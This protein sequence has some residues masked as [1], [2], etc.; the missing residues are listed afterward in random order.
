MLIREQR[1]DPNLYLPARPD[2]VDAG[3]DTQER[4]VGWHTGECIRGVMKELYGDENGGGSGEADRKDK[5]EWKW[6]MLLGFAW[7]AYMVRRCVSESGTIWQPGEMGVGTG[8]KGRSK[9]GRE[10]R[11]L[12][13]NADGYSPEVVWSGREGEG[14][15]T[16]KLVPVLEEFKYTKQT[17]NKGPEHNA[18]F[19]WRA[20]IKTYLKMLEI[21]EGV[22]HRWARLYAC[23]ANDDYKYGSKDGPEPYVCCWW[24]EFT[25]KEIDDNWRMLT[26]WLGKQ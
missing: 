11:T 19:K 26:S 17:S 6:I 14:S 25:R 8:L 1:L 13:G 2:F 5:V 12:Y 7:E 24:F 22:E 23:F 21:V 20:Q 10:K 4:A 9:D 15:S 3:T 18:H 16:G